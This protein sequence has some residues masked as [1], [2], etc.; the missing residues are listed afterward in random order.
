[1]EEGEVKEVR[2]MRWRW[3][4]DRGNWFIYQ[5]RKSSLVPA[6]FLTAQ[7][8]LFMKALFIWGI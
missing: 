3:R 7:F 5:A 1:M 6:G 2:Q 8:L 4:K